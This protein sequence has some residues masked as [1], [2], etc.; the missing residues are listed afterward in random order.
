MTATV[1]SVHSEL[2]VDYRK[3]SRLILPFFLVNST[4]LK[5]SEKDLMN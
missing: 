4:F 1:E 2:S 3:A 5:K